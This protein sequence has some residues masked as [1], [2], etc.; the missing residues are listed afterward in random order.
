MDE[1]TY[2][3]CL[4]T[5]VGELLLTSDGGAL[6]GL[7][8][9]RPGGAVPRPEWLRDDATFRAASMQL[10]AYFACELRTFDL[11]VR[12]AGTPFQMQVW[13]AL[14]TI[15]FAETISYAEL[16]RRVGRPGAARAV[17]AANGRNPLPIIFP[18]HRVIGAD[19]TLTGYGGGLD[20][21]R[22][23]LRHEAEACGLAAWAG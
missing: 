6:T 21:K 10:R 4:P 22:R 14:L 3:T 18:C 16:A 11:P 23:L 20:L 9:P 15:P 2:F 13:R 7:R 12:P 5:P 1:I 19:G 17:G 8:L